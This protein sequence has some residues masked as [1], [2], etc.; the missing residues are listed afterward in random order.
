MSDTTPQAPNSA[1]VGGNQDQGQAPAPQAAQPVPAQ[2]AQAPAQAPA[3]Q[4]PSPQATAPQ[5]PTSAPV[6]GNEDQAADQDMDNEDQD[7][8]DQDALSRE[9][10]EA[11]DQKVRRN[12][13]K[14]R[15]E[16]ANLRSRLATETTRA[17]RAE[18]A[19]AAGIPAEA[20]KFLTG[21]T[22]EE[23]EANA[24][25]LLVVMGGQGRVTPLGTP[26][27]AA[28]QVG[29]PGTSVEVNTGEDLDAIGQR[30]YAR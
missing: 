2:Q 29:A 1:P 20:L 24:A 10:L 17:D 28:A 4:A 7:V 5:A 6:G 18:V 22:R 8:L 16:A 21:S 11:L 13:S 26:Q 15:R 25:D 23:L 9:E 30:I 12:M 19:L 14:T 3:P 27:E